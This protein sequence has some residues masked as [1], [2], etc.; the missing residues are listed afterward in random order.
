MT[1]SDNHGL[2]AAD[3][4]G[5]LQLRLRTGQVLSADGPAVKSFVALAP[6]AGSAGAA[7]GYDNLG[8][9]AV[10]A[11]FVGGTQSLLRLALP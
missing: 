4:S 1:A 10:L 8:D 5:A 6:S 2:W 9:V 11:L 3:H 7:S